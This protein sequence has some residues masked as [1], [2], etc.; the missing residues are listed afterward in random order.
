MEK[1]SVCVCVCV[2]VSWVSTQS[3]YFD[4]DKG[5]HFDKK[6]SNGALNEEY[7]RAYNSDEH[8]RFGISRVHLFHHWRRLLWIC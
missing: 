2:C 8:L 4:V 1:G 5:C 3:C 7:T 6:L